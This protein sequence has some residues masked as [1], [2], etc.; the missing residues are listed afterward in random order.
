MTTETTDL[1]RYIVNPGPRTPVSGLEAAVTSDSAIATETMM[2][3][4]RKGG[5]AADAAIAGSLV[6]ATVEPYMTNHA[7][8]ITFLCYEAKT[9]KV[10][11]L[12]SQGSHPSGLSPFRPLPQGH[13]PF[14]AGMAPSAIIPGCMPGLKAIHEKFGTQ[15]WA[16]LCED[17]VEWAHRGHP[18]SS[19]EYRQNN[20]NE[21]FITYFPESREFYMPNGFFPAVGE[22]AVPKDLAATLTG[23][24]DHGPDYMISGPWAQAFVGKANE[25]GWPIHLKHMAESPARWVEPIRFKHH[26][27][28]VVTLGPPQSH[29]FVAAVTLGVLKHLGIREMR[30][31]SADH[32][33]AMGHAL[34]QGIRHCEYAQDDEIYGVPREEILDDQYHACLARMI[35]R[36]RPKVDLTEHIRLSGDSPGLGSSVVGSH[37]PPGRPRRVKMVNDQPVGSCEIAVVDAEGN[38]VQMLN[39]LQG[40]GIPGQ[41]VGGVT[42]FGSLATFGHLNSPM[43][44]T[45]VKGAKVRCVV[46][47]TLVLQNGK[48]V[49]SVGTP[50]IPHVTAPQVLANLLDFKL[51]PG[52]AVDA[53]RMYPMTETRGVVYEDR[54]D[55]AVVDGLHKLGVRAGVVSPYDYNLGSFSVIAR[56]TRTGKLTAVEDPRR[57]AVADGIR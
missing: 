22:I 19:F 20:L 40:S 17:A 51:D 5:S 37:S 55:P 31:G 45:L 4:L 44:S 25:M 46:A 14:A 39:T 2:K 29:G 41:V 10:Y 36:S 1:S 23:V 6:Q 8:L 9:G 24:R 34:R 21:Q 57:C 15:S 38:W 56:D 53:P 28:E 12:E 49:F 47:N 50:G 30:H 26:E 3:I 7:G 11:Q 33:W 42:M 18:V 16:S 52:A 35:R 27:Y 54:M 48:P 13:G 43:D 32:L